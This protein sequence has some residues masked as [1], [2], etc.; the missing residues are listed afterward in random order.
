MRVLIAGYQHETNTFAATKADWAAFNR[1]D[2]FPAFIEGQ[3]MLDSMTGVNL[4][5]GGFIDAA[6]ERGWELVP[7]S[8]CGAG[9]SA[10]VTEDAFERISAALLG[11]VRD[12]EFDALYIDFHGAG[13]AEHVDDTEGELLRRLRQLVGYDLPIVT[14]LDLHAN[15]TYQMLTHADAMAAFRT[16]PHVDM[17]DAGKLAASLLQRRLTQGAREP[18]AYRRLPFLIP[19]NSQ[20]TWLSPA[21]EHYELMRELDAKNDTVSSFCMGFPAADFPEC[22]PMLWTYG[23][24]ASVTLDALY[25]AVSEPSQWRLKN[26]YLP[27]AS[28]QRALTLA[29]QSNRPII[30]ADTQDNPSG[31]AD[32]NTSGMVHALLRNQAGRRFPGQV[33]VGLIYDPQTARQAAQAGV[34]A[35]IDAE[36]GTAAPTF[37]GALSEPPVKARCKVVSLSDGQVTLEGPMMTGLTTKL[38]QCACLDIDG[39][40]VIVASG[41]MQLLDRVQIR[42]MGL[43]A[44]D[45][46]VIV[47]KS[48]N[49]FRA[50]MSSLVRDVETD[51]LIVKCPGPKA[52][53]P[54]DYRW[55]RLPA[56]I[57]RQP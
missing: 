37:T 36:V 3:A 31:G 25:A 24:N 17:A 19:T 1:G 53:D 26:V 56:S 47:I 15:V 51:I 45:M 43:M 32:G 27:D 5:A 54:A 4:P 6:R 13:V 20:S 46:K 34:G 49:H 44:Q 48:A 55:T 30:I 38:G 35:T 33:V 9:P 21:K 29:E 2:S 52:V 18:M 16:Y 50:D 42:M 11:A 57:D 41:K 40:Y 28:V 39:V 8:W 7:A 23:A 12:S 10:H 22:G 14:S